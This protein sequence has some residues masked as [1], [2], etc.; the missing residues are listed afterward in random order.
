MSQLIAVELRQNIEQKLQ[1]QMCHYASD[2]RCADFSL[3]MHQKRFGGRALPRSAGKPTTLPR[4]VRSK[5]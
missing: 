3:K 4:L 2:K 1:V 5:E